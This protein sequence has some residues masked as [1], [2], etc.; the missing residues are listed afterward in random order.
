M[1]KVGIQLLVIS[2]LLPESFVLASAKILLL[3][4]LLFVAVLV[5]PFDPYP[6]LNFELF[7]ILVC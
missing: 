5:N 2:Y 1:P 6:P 4:S 3:V 7:I